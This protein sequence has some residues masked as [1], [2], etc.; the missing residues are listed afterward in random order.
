MP[1]RIFAS[2][3]QRAR[4][5]RIGARTA[6][7]ANDIWGRGAQLGGKIEQVP[8]RA[9]LVTAQPGKATGTLA[10]P[11]TRPARELIGPCRERRE[12]EAAGG[13]GRASSRGRLR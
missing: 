12:V 13:G 2:A 11:S 7:R 10:G 9:D 8:G 5:G 3:E 1:D 4:L 6:Q